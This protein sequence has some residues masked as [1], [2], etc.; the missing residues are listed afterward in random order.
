MHP[1]NSSALPA[2]AVAATLLATYCAPTGPGNPASAVAKS[3]T[4]MAFCVDEINRYRALVGQPALT[5]SSP[6]EDYA[7]DSARVDAAARVAHRHFTEQNGGGVARA[8]NELLAWPN[9]DVHAVLEQ[10]LASMWNEGPTGEHYQ[11][12]IGPYTEV[13]CGLAV[14]G[15]D[16]TI[17]QD[18]R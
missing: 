13:G 14:T 10:G 15:A 9:F 18:F 5:R 1:L 12:M 11:I 17:A 16:I 6:L 2:L 3:S 8:E 4:E 7:A